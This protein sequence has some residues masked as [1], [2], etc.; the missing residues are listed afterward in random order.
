MLKNGDLISFD[1]TEQADIDRKKIL[2][3]L[4]PVFG[5][6]PAAPEPPAQ[7]GSG[8]NPFDPEEDDEWADPM[9]WDDGVQHH[10]VL[11]F[12]Q[13]GIQL[14][15]ESM[16]IWHLTAPALRVVREVPYCP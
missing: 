6:S 2:D 8:K 5:Y 4:G 11:L 10:A 3:D 9:Q 16:S 15:S 12:Q 13:G 14:G 7:Q 1:D